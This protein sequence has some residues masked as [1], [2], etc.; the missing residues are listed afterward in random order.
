MGIGKL[1]SFILVIIIIV[2]SAQ[3]SIESINNVDSGI[4]S[5]TSSLSF[6][7][8]ITHDVSNDRS[9]LA[10]ASNYDHS[11]PKP[12]SS[13]NNYQRCEEITIPMCRGIG[14]NFTAMP[15]E[16]NHDTQEEAGLEVHQFWPLV[17]IKCSSDLKFF[18][19]SMYTPICLPEYTKPLPACK[20][21]CERAR[22]GCAPLMQQ[23]GFS[24]PERMACE[25]L[26]SQGDS[27]NLCMEQDNKTLLSTDVIAQSIPPVLL[28]K[29]TK[30]S[31]TIQSVKCK[32]GKNQKNCL[33]SNNNKEKDC[34]CRCRPPLISLVPSNS[35]KESSG[36]LNFDPLVIS[37]ITGFLVTQKLDIIGVTDCVLPCQ[38]AFLT[39]EEK[40]FATVWLTL[41]S[42]LCA[43]STLATVTTFLIDTQRFKYPERPIVFLSACYF[44]VSLGYLS[45]SVVGHKEIACDGNMLRYG[46]NG[47]G[48]CIT[49]FLLIYF[50][51]M[52]SSVWWVILAFTWFLA[53]GLKWG[54]EAIASYSQYFHLAA[55]MAPTGQTVWALLSGGI[56]GDPIAGV[57]TVA[58]EGIPIFILAPL[59]VYLLLG[60]TFLLAGFVSLFR[61][62]SVIK[63]QPGAK[64]DKLEKL[65][66]RIGIFSV[67]YTVPASAVLACYL[68]E[69]TSR[70]EWLNSLAC[71]CKTRVR[72]LY[73]VIMLKYFMAL[74]VGITSGVWIWSGKTIDSWRKLWRRLC[75]KNSDF[76]NNFT[77]P[78][79]TRVTSHIVGSKGLVE[80]TVTSQYLTP[81][82]PSSTLLQQSSITNTS[83]HHIHHHVL[84]QP[85]ISHV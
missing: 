20:S 27:D 78:T 72:P 22:T 51:G 73:S 53:A 16:L 81:S 62:R 15:N 12:D 44:L 6:L 46:T 24:W 65:M 55:W 23:Y 8:S 70:G 40:S 75:S 52:A 61:I 29:P 18:L 68:Y 47:P 4:S 41:W 69:T 50:F 2:Y 71:P 63:R 45:R 76:S 82:G 74:A 48:I 54:N 66:I 84:R 19:C 56:A 26:P 17:E 28:S 43:A 49:V 1:F 32:P 25:R 38:G 14:Y 33:Y 67:L 31:K 7:S 57:C 58:S 64:A 39:S 34:T 80:R 60:T 30:S 79:G 21:V 9:K 83:Q 59:L 35:L 85:P 13:N 77:G 42:G 10:A 37:D 36:I 3:D 11:I 5:S